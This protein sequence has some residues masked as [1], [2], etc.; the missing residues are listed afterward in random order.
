MSFRIFF[1]DDYIYDST[2]MFK[3]H[4][5]SFT[6]KNVT[7]DLK[8]N[9]NQKR[10]HKLKKKFFIYVFGLIHQQENCL[11]IDKKIITSKISKTINK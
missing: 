5:F 10:N 8:K 6:K 7:F 11:S 3:S 2:K 1:L 9:L 4:K